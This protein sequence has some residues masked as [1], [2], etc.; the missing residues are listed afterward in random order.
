MAD[1][2]ACGRG[3]CCVRMRR[4]K[5]AAQKLVQR[6]LVMIQ[7]ECAQPLLPVAESARALS[8]TSLVISQFKE[9]SEFSRMGMYLNS[10]V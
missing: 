4:K 10:T 8:Y 3:G 5:A 2:V 9:Y 1:A 7:R 6:P